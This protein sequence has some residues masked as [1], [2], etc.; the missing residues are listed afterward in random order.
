VAGNKKACIHPSGSQS[1]LAL[2]FPHSR[3]RQ[4]KPQKSQTAAA[5]LHFFYTLFCVLVGDAAAFARSGELRR[6]WRTKAFL[7]L[8]SPLRKATGRSRNLEKINANFAEWKNHIWNID[9]L[10]FWKLLL[11]KEAR[12]AKH[13]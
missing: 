9:L 4:Q 13:F 7:I 12:V 3:K 11:L 10:L 5:L 2:C 6:Y 1:M 8:S